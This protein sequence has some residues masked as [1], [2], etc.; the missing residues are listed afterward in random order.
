MKLN[1]DEELISEYIKKTQKKAKQ[2]EKNEIIKSIEN[3]LY[4]KK[5]SRRDN[6]IFLD[7][8]IK[9][10]LSQDISSKYSNFV[11]NANKIIIDDILENYNNETIDFIFNLK[12]SDWLDVFLKK[13]EFSDLGFKNDIS[14]TMNV[15]VEELFRKIYAENEKNYLSHF[16]LYIYNFERSLKIIKPRKSKKEVNNDENEI[17][18]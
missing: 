8:N 13:K 12:V 1:L 10:L 7:I 18:Q 9:E 3:Q 15:G 16:F 4:G 17:R 11:K 2:I 5:T 14:L 6:L